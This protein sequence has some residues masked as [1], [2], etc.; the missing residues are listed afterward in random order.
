M[1][2]SLQALRRQRYG[3][4]KQLQKTQS[5]SLRNRRSCET[6]P[7]GDPQIPA[8]FPRQEVVDVPMPGHRRSLVVRRVD[9]HA[10]LASV[11]EQMAAM[12]L[13]VPDQVHALHGAAIRNGSRMTDW[14]A[15]ALSANSRFASRT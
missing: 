14:P 5:K 7:R 6:A 15:N 11:T 10:V 12:R 8:D 3:V 1:P 2:A 4:S 13:K 9:V